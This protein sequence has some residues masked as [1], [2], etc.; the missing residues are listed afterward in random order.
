VVCAPKEDKEERSREKK[1]L[2][3]NGNETERVGR[4]MVKG[5]S[6]EANREYIS[7]IQ[8]TLKKL[9]KQIASSSSDPPE[10]FSSVGKKTSRGSSLANRSHNIPKDM[11]LNQLWNNRS[12]SDIAA[13]NQTICW[14]SQLSSDQ[15]KI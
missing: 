5:I 7:Q 11:E 12:C 14:T 2:S 13:V 8:S 3:S 1:G 9:Q 4:I 15:R 10:I 6:P